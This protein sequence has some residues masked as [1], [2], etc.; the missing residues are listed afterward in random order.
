[1]K[2]IYILIF[3]ALIIGILIGS[4]IPSD[5]EDEHEKQFNIEGGRTI[6]NAQG[7]AYDGRH[8]YLT[9]SA[10]GELNCLY[11]LDRE[12]EVILKRVDIIPSILLDYD[13]IGDLD[14]W[15]GRLYIPIEHKQVLNGLRINASFAVY[16]PELSFT[17][18]YWITSQF[19][20][21]WCAIDPETGYL[22]SSEWN[23]VSTLYIYDLENFELLEILPLNKTLSR[24]QGGCFYKGDLWIS[25][26]D[27]EKSICRV[28]PETGEVKEI[29][30]TEIPNEMEGI[31]A[32][33][34]LQWVD[35]E[36][37]LYRYQY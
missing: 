3:I 33:E 32:F 22:Y 2:K 13:H 36:G 9:T 30:K 7:I 25:C 18:E 5:S 35:H 14:F 23:D 20:A 27:L 31:T 1:M 19:H 6:Q 8:F 4:F 15:N 16:D 34:G 12:G 21:P 26:D 11:I 37:Y 29:L 10:G 28:D 17:G 24:V